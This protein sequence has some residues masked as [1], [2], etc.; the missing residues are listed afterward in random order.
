M[1]LTVHDHPFPDFLFLFAV[2]CPALADI[3]NGG[4][5]QNNG[6]RIGNHAEY[7]CDAGYELDGDSHRYCLIDGTWSGSE[8]ACIVGNAA[9][10]NCQGFHPRSWRQVPGGDRLRILM[11]SNVAPMTL[12]PSHSL[13]CSL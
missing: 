5:D 4:V 7:D 10:Y 2:D 11:A 3:S 13:Q 12:P 1:S 9:H 8:P 6:R